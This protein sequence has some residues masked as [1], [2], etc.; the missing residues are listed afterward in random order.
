MRSF[1]D[2]NVVV[3]AFD[4]AEPAKQRTALAV[5]ESDDRLVVSTQVLLE[6]W[7]TLT[8][9]LAAPLSEDQATAVVDEL[10]RLPVVQTDSELVKRA[11]RTSCHFRIALWDGLTVE[12]A[13]AAGCRRILSED[14][15]QGQDFAGVVVEN[16]F[17]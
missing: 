16:P 8:R 5:L 17:A 7:W 6:A 13:R 14:L 10:C 2:T 15:Q 3:Y 11:I 9:K 12:A 4:G 1:L